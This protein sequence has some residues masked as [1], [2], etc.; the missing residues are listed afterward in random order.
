MSQYDDGFS[1]LPPCPPGP[2]RFPEAPEPPRIN[3]FL[4][5]LDGLFMSFHQ[6]ANKCQAFGDFEQAMYYKGKADATREAIDHYK[7]LKP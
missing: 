5:L 7:E 3:Y 6:A 4:A 1:H 2:N